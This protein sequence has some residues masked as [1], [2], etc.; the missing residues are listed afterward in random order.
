MSATGIAFDRRC[1]LNVGSLARAYGFPILARAAEH[2][3]QVMNPTFVWFDGE[4]QRENYTQEFSRGYSRPEREYERMSPMDLAES[5]S[6]ILRRLLRDVEDA[7]EF[8]EARMTGDVCST[9]GV[10]TLLGRHVVPGD[11]LT[12]ALLHPLELLFGVS[13]MVDGERWVGDRVIF[14][15]GLQVVAGES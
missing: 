3:R 14:E 15:G 12:L 4:A 5:R 6:Q 8:G 9:G 1:T 2:V 10:L 7:F 13:T 11:R